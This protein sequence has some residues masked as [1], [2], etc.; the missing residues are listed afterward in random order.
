MSEYI[1]I[2]TSLQFLCQVRRGWI[3]SGSLCQPGDQ[4][5]PTGTQEGRL[6]HREGFCL[7]CLGLVILIKHSSPLLSRPYLEST[8]FTQF[9]GGGG[10]GG[11]SSKDKESIFFAFEAAHGGKRMVFAKDP[12]FVLL[13][14][15]QHRTPAPLHL[16]QSQ[17][18]VDRSAVF[19]F[20][21]YFS[22]SFT[23]VAVLKVTCWR[24]KY[25]K[26]GGVL[27]PIHHEEGYP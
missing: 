10:E 16:G 4:L 14:T 2:Q 8:E 19:S 20:V 26:M 15:K 18:K 5:G 27:A 1:H 22:L 24:W 6:L 25:P 7:C 23:S 17:W 21:G 11:L 13:F 12:V 9:L 3:C